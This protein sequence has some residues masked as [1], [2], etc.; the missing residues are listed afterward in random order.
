MGWS[1]LLSL[2]GSSL[3]S[4]P[5]WLLFGEQKVCEVAVLGEK[6]SSAE[7]LSVGDL[8]EGQQEHQY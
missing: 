2:H 5:F 1:N 7:W 6:P 4:R 3:H 8:D